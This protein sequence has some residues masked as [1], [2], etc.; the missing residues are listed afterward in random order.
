MFCVLSL[1]SKSWAGLAGWRQRVKTIKSTLGKIAGWVDSVLF[2]VAVQIETTY[3]ARSWVL[4]LF[5]TCRLLS[6]PPKLICIFRRPSLIRLYFIVMLTF[7]FCIQLFYWFFLQLV[8]W[9]SSTFC[10][11]FRFVGYS[12]LKTCLLIWSA[13]ISGAAYIKV[14]WPLS[15]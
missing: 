10:F 2:I 14:A 3:I 15:C 1:G 13:K 5:L 4:H 7:H 9:K 11:G 12:G 6:G 8:I